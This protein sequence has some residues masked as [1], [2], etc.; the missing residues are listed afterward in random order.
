MPTRNGKYTNDCALQKMQMERSHRSRAKST[1]PDTPRKLR[2]CRGSVCQPGS[3]WTK[4]AGLL[5]VSHLSAPP[6]EAV[7]NKGPPLSL[8]PMLQGWPCPFVS[9]GLAVARRLLPAVLTHLFRSTRQLRPGGV[10]G[11]GSQRPIVGS[12]CAGCFL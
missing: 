7:F 12:N 11:Q 1:S 9:H 6:Q 10:E 3:I 8:H 2:T 4:Y 5:Q